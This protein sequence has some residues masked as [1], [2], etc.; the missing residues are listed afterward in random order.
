M[1]FKSEAERLLS[2][3]TGF[4]C[5]DSANSRAFSS[6]TS[7]FQSGRIPLQLHRFILTPIAQ[8]NT[9][10]RSRRSRTSRSNSYSR[11]RSRSPHRSSHRRQRKRESPPRSRHVDA[12]PPSLP[13]GAMPLSKRDLAR[14]EPMFGMYLDIQKGIDIAEISEREMK[15]RWKSF[16]GKW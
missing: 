2:L 4:R 12:I 6:A 9:M 1:N 11:S 16:M 14:Y 7:A 15:G 3:G 13:L 10:D 5:Q 8:K